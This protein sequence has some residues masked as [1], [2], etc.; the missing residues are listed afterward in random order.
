M[1]TEIRPESEKAL[2]RAILDF[3]KWRNDIFVWRQNTGAAKYEAKDGSKR[4]IR[5]GVAGMPDIM[6]IQRPYGHLIGIECKVGK[7]S[8]NDAQRAMQK[9]FEYRGATYILARSVDDVLARLQP[10]LGPRDG[11]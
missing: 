10:T 11:V 5:Y 6:C 9:E 3:L 1:P 7:N 2:V 8:Q 4:F